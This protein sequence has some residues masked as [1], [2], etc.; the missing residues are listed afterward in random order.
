MSLNNDGSQSVEAVEPV[1][2][3]RESIWSIIAGIFSRPAEAFAAYVKHP[4]L[5]VLIILSIVL[6]VV[7]A[8]ASIP[9]QSFLQY[10]I[11][12]QSTKLPPQALEE[13]KKAADNPDW[14]LGIITASAGGIFIGF[15]FSAVTALLAWGIG[16]FIFGGLST[17]KKIWGVTLLGG[18]ISLI[19]GLIRIIFVTVTG[20]NYFSL[21]L[22]A[23]F[24]DKD[25]TSLMYG[26]LY[27]VD[28]FVVW[29][30]IVI[31]IG[32]AAALGVSRGKGLA[33]SI[34]VTLIG[35][36]G[37]LLPMFLMSLAGVEITIF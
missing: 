36:L 2:E 11:M 13:M 23:M 5:A 14:G 17:F 28:L 10:D 9:N 31:G 35:I 19:G 18:L 32:Y 27:R 15:G 12:K 29:A 33:I 37:S 8:I 21:G 24:P 16:S 26:L 30:V 4:T 7:L 3:E 20:N 34:I 22:A 25:F 1:A 6:V